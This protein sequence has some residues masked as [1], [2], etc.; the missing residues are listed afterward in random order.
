MDFFLLFAVSQVHSKQQL[1]K[2][3]CPITLDELI[4]FMYWLI[5]NAQESTVD[6][7]CTKIKSVD[8]QCTRINIMETKFYTLSIA[9][10]IT[11]FQVGCL[12]SKENLKHSHLADDCTSGGEG[13]ADGFTCTIATLHGCR[14]NAHAADYT[15]TAAG[16]ASTES[17]LVRIRP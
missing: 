17:T 4:D 6:K 16:T 7:Q 8:K 13:A 1:L 11:V 2:Q 3:K 14:I 10:A 9:L 15:T 5:N 12:W